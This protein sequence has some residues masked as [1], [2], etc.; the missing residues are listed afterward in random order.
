MLA[1]WHYH[2]DALARALDGGDT[3]L[4]ELPNPGWQRIH[5]A[6]AAGAG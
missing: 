1:G 5:E 3:E 4:V 6:Y 2:L